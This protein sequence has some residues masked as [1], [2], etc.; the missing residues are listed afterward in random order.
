MVQILSKP[1]VGPVMRSYAI[2]ARGSVVHV[3]ALLQ[4][5][6]LFHLGSANRIDTAL[7][8]SASNRMAA[9]A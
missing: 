1:G 7:Q 4:L 6:A 3:T 5:G 9:Q 8:I 2:F